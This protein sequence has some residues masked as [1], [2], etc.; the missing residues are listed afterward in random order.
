M[1]RVLREQLDRHPRR[2]RLRARA[3]RDAGGSRAANDELTAVSLRAGR[4]MAYFFPVVM[5]V[6]NVSSVAVLWF[7]AGRVDSG[8]MQIG[9]LTAFLTYLAQILMSVMMATFMVMMVPRAAVCAERIQQVL[10]TES[11]VA[12]AE[13]SRG[14]LLRAG[15]V[16]E[17]RD[18]S[19]G[20]GGAEPVVCDVSFVAR[21]G[22]TTAIIGST[23]AG[24][25]TL[26]S[27]VP[28]LFDVTGGAVLVDGMDVRD[29]DPE[30]LWRRLGLVPQRAFLFSG[31]VASNLR[32]GDPDATDDELWQAL[33]DR[34][35]ARLRRGDAGAASTR[36]SARAGRTCPAGSGSGSRSRARSSTARRCT[37]STSRSRRSTSA[38]T[39]GCAR[40]CVRSRA[41]PP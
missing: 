24:K 6:L 31:T 22:T 32:H 25:S 37:C 18:V 14:R 35:G 30:V 28:R 16:V 34:A 12:P 8:Q 3:G 15:G 4:L 39:R 2:P 21:P 23:G 10:D 33:T 38:P 40:R 17:F 11:S 20:Y 36:R 27:L 5:V 19:F 26:V 7:G 1:N 29:Y 13:R 41:T 9:S